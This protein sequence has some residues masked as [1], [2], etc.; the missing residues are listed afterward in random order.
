[1]VADFEAIREKRNVLG[2]GDALLALL[3]ITEPTDQQQVGALLLGAL[4]L[5]HLPPPKK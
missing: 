1:M 4:V 3:G 2:A 5:S